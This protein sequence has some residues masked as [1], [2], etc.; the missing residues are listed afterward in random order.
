MIVCTIAIRDYSNNHHTCVISHSR[1]LSTTSR[2]GN[3]SLTRRENNDMCV[4]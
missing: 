4:F 3:I 1:K 2:P